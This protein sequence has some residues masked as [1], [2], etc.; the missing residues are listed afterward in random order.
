MTRL[1]PMLIVLISLTGCE[2]ISSILSSQPLP[3]DATRA[4]L[5]MYS[6]DKAYKFTCVVNTQTKALTNCQEVQ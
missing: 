6:G 4:D 3:A 1:L 5:V 2:A